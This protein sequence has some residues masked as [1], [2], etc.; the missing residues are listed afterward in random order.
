MVLDTGHATLARASEV[1]E[2]SRFNGHT[3]FTFGA[4]AVDQP[5]SMT[6]G[7][8]ADGSDSAGNALSYFQWPNFTITPLRNARGRSDRGT[9]SSYYATDDGGTT[10]SVAYN[11]QIGWENYQLFPLGPLHA[12]H[13]SILQGK[14]NEVGTVY[15]RARVYDP[16]TGQFT[17]E[18]PI[19]LAGGLNAYG[20]AGGDPVNYDDPFGTCIGPLAAVCVLIGEVL[21]D[22]SPE[23]LIAIGLTATT[24]VIAS[25]PLSANDIAAIS[26]IG[27]A[28]IAAD[29]ANASSTSKPTA[30]D[31]V[32]GVLD[33]GGTFKPHAT[34][35][36]QGVTIHLPGATTVNVRVETHGGLHGNVERKQDGKK[37]GNKHIRPEPGEPPPQLTPPPQ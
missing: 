8:Y 3:L 17:Q 18:D 13:G 28:P 19:G 4:G 2:N 32:Q 12:W 10:H 23:I 26:S 16:A 9:F 37:A 34:N 6:R 27:T 15:R 33:L 29:A 1:V 24:A 35:T 36:G 30:G 22:A 21:A 11:L 20:F 31:I 7:N 5:L 25:H 14:L